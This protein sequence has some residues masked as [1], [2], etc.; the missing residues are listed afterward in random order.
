VPNELVI[1]KQGEHSLLRNDMR[2]TL[3]NKLVAFLA[4]N[5]DP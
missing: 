2:I 3:Y 5:L 1:I 4:A